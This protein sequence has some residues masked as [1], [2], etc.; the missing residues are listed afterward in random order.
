M[1]LV[2]KLI[3]FTKMILIKNEAKKAFVKL[4]TDS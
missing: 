1:L 3:A 4:R 2:H